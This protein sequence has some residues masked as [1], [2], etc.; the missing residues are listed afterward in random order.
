MQYNIYAAFLQYYDFPLQNNMASPRVDAK[1]DQS[2]EDFRK[3]LHNAVTDQILARSCR[4]C[5]HKR[6]KSS[7]LSDKLEVYM[8]DVGVVGLAS[9]QCRRCGRVENAA[10]SNGS[11]CDDL[12]SE[13]KVQPSMSVMAANHA[14]IQHHEVLHDLLELMLVAATENGELRR[15]QHTGVASF[16]FENARRVCE[17][18]CRAE[19][20]E[21]RQLKYLRLRTETLLTSPQV[22]TSISPEYVE[23]Y[24][25]MGRTFACNRDKIVVLLDLMRDTLFNNPTVHSFMMWVTIVMM[26]VE[27]YT[28]FKERYRRDGVLQFD[29]GEYEG[30]LKR[31]LSLEMPMGVK[32]IPVVFVLF[33]LP[34]FYHYVKLLTDMFGPSGVPKVYL[35][36]SERAAYRSIDGGAEMPSGHE[37]VKRQGTLVW[38]QDHLDNL[39][40]RSEEE[41]RRFYERC[42]TDQDEEEEGG[43]G[44]RGRDDSRV[45]P[46]IAKDGK[47]NPPGIFFKPKPWEPHFKKGLFPAPPVNLIPTIQLD[48]QTT[49][50]RQA[51]PTPNLLDSR[52]RPREKRTIIVAQVDTETLRKQGYKV[53]G[54]YDKATIISSEDGTTILEGEA[55]VEEIQACVSKDYDVF[56][57]QEGTGYLTF[58]PESE[59]GPTRLVSAKE[60]TERHLTAQEKLEEYLAEHRN[61]DRRKFPHLNHPRKTL[62]TSALLPPR[63]QTTE[64]L[65]KK[66]KE[67]KKALRS[68][69]KPSITQTLLSYTGL[70]STSAGYLAIPFTHGVDGPLDAHVMGALDQLR[71]QTKQQ[72]KNKR[73]GK[74]ADGPPPHPPGGSFPPQA[75]PF[76]TVDHTGVKAY[77]LGKDLNLMNVLGEKGLMMPI[78]EEVKGRKDYGGGGGGGGGAAGAEDGGGGG[79]GGGKVSKKKKKKNKKKKTVETAKGKVLAALRP[80]V[81]VCSDVK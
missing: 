32:K 3:R 81:C 77:V 34:R 6:D 35:N 29:A 73:R 75:S 49:V 61:I 78:E 57:H 2:D 37:R 46:A 76:T 80:K 70:D 67:K 16:M 44:R 53:D 66:L 33:E 63:A 17:E 14:C 58:Q 55:S 23:M 1:S 9:V 71:E 69:T 68:G 12:P 42:S 39:N 72:K 26:H 52:G 38:P 51:I 15:E 40:R 5:G 31:Y 60:F 18:W 20:A 21:L 64:E 22:P 8:L 11:L 10:S 79:G 28:A 47:G 4:S 30:V 62:P 50:V 24:E 7:L 74:D 59:K 54:S 19:Y 25:M 43:R 65:R 41:Q 48:P 36:K 45:K 13:V 56:A 27:K